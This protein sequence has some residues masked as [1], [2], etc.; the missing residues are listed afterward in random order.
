[1]LGPAAPEA[2]ALASFLP[3]SSG[4]PINEVIAR[5]QVLAGSGNV[6][7]EMVKDTGV[8]GPA[9]LHAGSGSDAAKGAGKHSEPA[10]PQTVAAGRDAASAA[11]AKDMHADA[12]SASETPADENM[13]IAA[14]ETAMK[15]RVA[16]DSSGDAL[17]A[18]KGK[19]ARYQKDKNV[20]KINEFTSKVAIA[21]KTHETN[22]A[23]AI[24]ANDELL[25]IRKELDDKAKAERR[26]ARKPG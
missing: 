18:K 16:R 15:A 1:V 24:R 22:K 12:A 26:A 21:S 19:L 5:W 6:G 8:G 11:D 20:D 23:A 7:S 25:R 13:L 2:P 4:L 17:Q 10:C 3:P 14:Q 9:S